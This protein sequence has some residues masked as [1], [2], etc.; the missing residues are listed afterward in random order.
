[1]QQTRL[2]AVHRRHPV[3]R[4]PLHE[5]HPQ[6]AYGLG[7]EGL[8]HEVARRP[9]QELQALDVARG[10]ILHE[11]LDVGDHGCLVFRRAE[12][13]VCGELQ[14]LRTQVL[15]ACGVKVPAH[16]TGRGE[17]GVEWEEGPITS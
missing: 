8:V 1:M 12:L 17:T 11:L 7:E 6:R 15:V 14:D 9:L 13:C 2:E 5:P 3:L 4:V 10:A 16:H